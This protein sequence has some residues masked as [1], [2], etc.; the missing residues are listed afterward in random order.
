[1]AESRY[2]PS[3]TLSVRSLC[4]NG[5]AQRQDRI[6]ERLQTMDEVGHIAGFSV[7]IWG[8]RV[9]RDGGTATDRA[10]RERI[11]TFET[12]SDRVGVSLS[13]FFATGES[14][15]MLTEETRTIINLPI[16]CLAEYHHDALQ[17]V[18]PCVDDG[19][20]CTMSDRLDA[21]ERGYP[22]GKRAEPG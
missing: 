3:I 7:E 6:I 20:V 12:W 4:P 1:M 11:E 16:V 8:D 10:V 5:A 15:S 19:T 22:D 13:P 14:R 21:L 18:A 2:Q 9:P 17:Y